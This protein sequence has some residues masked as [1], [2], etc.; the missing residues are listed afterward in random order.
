MAPTAS[1]TGTCRWRST[2]RDVSRRSRFGLQRGPSRAIPRHSFAQAPSAWAIAAWRELD[3]AILHLRLNEPEVGLV[4]LRTS[5]DRRGRARRRSCGIATPRALAGA[6]DPAAPE[7]RA[8]AARS[9]RPYVLRDH[10]AGLGLRRVALR[11][12]ARGRSLLHAGVERGSAGDDRA[13][14]DERGPAADELGSVAPA[15]PASSAR[16]HESPP[17]SRTMARS[18]PRR[19][20][21]PASSRSR[22]T[23]S[24]GTTRCGWRS[25]SAPR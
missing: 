12:G 14:A 16:K 24:T 5:G 3:D 22:P 6:R 23:T 20:S 7:A 19:L 2:A 13:L 15:A 9:H 25:R 10:R 18:V 1:S 4:L 11:A 8:E 17:C 21:T